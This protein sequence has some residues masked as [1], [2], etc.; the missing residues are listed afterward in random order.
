MQKDRKLVIYDIVLLVASL[1]FAMLLRFDFSIPFEYIGFLKLSLIPVIAITLVFNKFFKLYN[2]IWKYASIEELMSIIYSISLSNVVFIIYSHFVNFRFL[3]NRYF[4]FPFSVHI[5]FW[6][7]SVVTLGGV[8]FLIRVVDQGKGEGEVNR[9]CKKLLIIGAGDASS[10]LIKEI[11]RHN[12]LNYDIVGLIDDDVS[13]KKKFISGVEVLGG[14]NDIVDICKKEKIEE[15]IIAIPSADID[16]KKDIINICKNTEC[17]L[18]TLPGIYEIVDGRVNIS[19]LRDVNIEDLLGREEVRL[20]NSNINK[21]IKDKVILVT[22]G[23]GSIGSEL[24]RQIARFNPRKLLILD[25]YENNVYSVQMELNYNHPELN[26]EVIIA[27][28]RDIDRM[29]DIFSQYSPDVVFHAAA[30]KHVPLMELNPKEAIKNNIL[31]TYNVLK[32]CNEF[33]V[34]K[35]VQISTDKA[36]NPTNIMGA[37]KRFCE[38]MVQAFNGISS[39]EYVA[40]RFGNVLGSNGSVIPL[41]KKQIAHGGPVTV[42]HPDINRFFMTIP[43]AAQLVIQAGA[44]AHGGEIFVL[45]MGKPVKIVDLARDL[46]TLSGYKPDVDIKIEYT[47]LRPGEKL[48]EEPLMN[49]IALTS[50]GHN[51][52]FV[53][54][55]DNVGIKFVEESILQFEKAVNDNRENIFKLMEQKVTT[56]KRKKS[57]EESA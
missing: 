10:I 45:D 36:V 25:I 13:K 50:T 26:K 41:F 18:K 55:P 53:E 23:G 32:C 34:K 46:I 40:V 7:L 6:M 35:F 29:R 1:Y 19:K 2:R 54:K 43:E 56:Y 39:T 27:S 28:I 15:I 47:G 51:K 11:K 5:I 8:R 48:Y 22:G 37:T 24:C 17:K 44:I 4:R 33:K 9:R 14:R 49:E 52:I 3:D 12:N 38:I 20:D 42:T 57:E 31:G 21:Y 30:H 16:A